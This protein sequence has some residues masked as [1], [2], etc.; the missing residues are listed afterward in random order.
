MKVAIRTDASLHIGTG[1]VMRSLAL[2]DRLRAAGADVLFI[3]RQHGGHL[4]DFIR[5]RGFAVAPLPAPQEGWQVPA[6]PPHAAW[7]GASWQQDAAETTAALPWRPDWLLVDHYAIERQWQQALRPAVGRIM[8]QDDLADRAHDC[9]LLL[10]QNAAA[11]PDTRYDALLPAHCQ[12]LL[13]PQYAML[14]PEFAAARAAL[15][16]RSG[17]V[18]RLFLFIGGADPANVTG[19]ALQAVAA[20]GRPGLAVDVVIGAANPHHEALA[21][22]CEALPGARLLRQ[23]DNI[24]ELMAQADL[25]IGAGGGA[26]WERCAVGLP[27]IVLAVAGNQ[28]PGCEAMAQAGRIL[29][30]GR[31]ERLAPGALEAALALAC[32]S[33]WLLRHLAEASLGLVDG[34]GAERV[35]RRMAALPLASMLQLRPATADDCDAIWAWRNAEQVRR[36][37]GDSAAIPLERHRAWYAGVLADPERLLLVGEIGG[38]PAGVLRYDRKQGQ[39]TVSVYLTPAFLGQGI[40]ASLVA[41]GSA[42]AARHWPQLERIEALVRPQNA[43]S[44]AVF[45][46]AGFAHEFEMFTQRIKA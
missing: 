23:V 20:L 37:S 31:A 9:D 41:A 39:A 2:A 44:A 33:P 24:A 22:Q 1:H 14:R 35:L 5:H 12:R 36:F 19:A 21:R 46:A 27:S 8:V 40:G 28:E 25:A 38:Q 17:A 10:D 6:E 15:A 26:M 7:L 32:A 45:A 13:G 18:R 3:C 11:I 4:C 29:Y 16:P 30:L 43:A 42:H 34:R